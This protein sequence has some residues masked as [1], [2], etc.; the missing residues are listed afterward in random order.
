MRAMISSTIIFALLILQLGGHPEDGYFIT[1]DLISNSPSADIREASLVTLA[2]VTGHSGFLTVDEKYNT[3]FFFWYFPPA[4]NL[5]KAPFILRLAGMN[6]TVFQDLFYGTGPY[7]LDESLN[8][9]PSKY[10]WHMFS[11]LLYI[12]YLPGRGF[13]FSDGGREHRINYLDI[14]NNLQ[15]A[16]TMF[17]DVFDNLKV[18]EIN[19]TGDS[20]G[21]VAAVTLASKLLNSKLN[22]TSKENG[23]RAM[24]LRSVLFLSG[25]LGL[26][27]QWYRA[28]LYED[29][30]LFLSKGQE[31]HFRDLERL[32]MEFM[33]S[34]NYDAVLDLSVCMT[35][36]RDNPCFERAT[37]RRTPIHMLF[38]EP[39]YIYA[40][41]VKQPHI[42]QM[43][44]VGNRGYNVGP[45]GLTVDQWVPVWTW[46]HV[47]NVTTTLIEDYEVIFMFGQFDM[48]VSYASS[49]T[50]VDSFEW[51]G[52]DSF[53]NSSRI[54]LRGASDE[55][56]AYVRSYDS[57][58]EIM[59]T[60]SGHTSACDQSRK[61][62]VLAKSIFSNLT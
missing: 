54:L 62:W 8:V 39:T 28:D 25:V 2:N 6:T 12:D 35:G 44:N 22:S 38:D 59:V 51:S 14:A 49:A 20:Q 18:D 58:T 50:M 32:N 61:V 10:S 55:I 29:F 33:T 43:L 19:L 5:E 30:G 7:R 1:A 17:F 26:E 3:N 40:D 4:N 21:A 60:D 53:K 16:L 31:K 15:V 56:Q 52:S 13:S 57:L 9:A 34:E 36:F 41:F 37:G 11:H 46:T 24:G 27:E 47:R 48:T 23:N 45:R 42:K